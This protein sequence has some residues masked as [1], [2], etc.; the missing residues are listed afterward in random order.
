MEKFKILT[1]FFL[2]FC[3]MFV[4]WREHEHED[5][6][7]VVVEDDDAMNS[8]RQCGMY[9]FFQTMVCEHKEGF[10]ISSLTIGIQMRRHSCLMGKH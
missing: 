6:D 5:V 4:Q 10:S 1:P 2:E 7:N 8:L 3:R 9:K